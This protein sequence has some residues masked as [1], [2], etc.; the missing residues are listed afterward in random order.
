[1]NATHRCL[2]LAPLIIL[3]AA[4]PALGQHRSFITADAGPY[5]RV[6]L[7]S[8]VAEDNHLTDFGGL[9]SGNKISYDV[10]FALDAAL[11]YAFNK[12]VAVELETGW[13]WNGINSIEGLYVDDTS[14][15][16]IPIMANVVLQYPIPRTLVVPYIGAGVGGAGTIL[17]TDGIYYPSGYGGLS[18]Y[19]A[20]SDF[21]FAYQG[22]AGVRVQ[23]SKEMQLGVGYKYY[24]SD[25]STFGDDDYY[26]YY[27]PELHLGISR[28]A[29]H[30]ASLT[31]TFKF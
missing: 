20:S 10:G 4:L 6:D 1:M 14:F 11:G 25:Q 28:Q 8:A 17:D 26:Y 9:T 19:G 16:T 2:A 24:V 15:S 5:W 13:T 12:Y 27:G 7:G 31:F 30:T 18:F 23:L 21:V 3:L 22:F 29:I